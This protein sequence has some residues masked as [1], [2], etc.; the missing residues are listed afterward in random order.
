MID[1]SFCTQ[2]LC[3][4]SDENITSCDCILIHRCAEMSA[5]V[6]WLSALVAC[7][8]PYGGFSDPI[9]PPTTRG[10]SLDSSGVEYQGWPYEDVKFNHPIQSPIDIITSQAVTLP[11]PVLDIVEP[12]QP[13][14]K[15]LVYNNGHNVYVYIEEDPSVRPYLIGGPLKQKFIFQQMHFHWGA[16][17]IWG[18][19]HLVDGNSYSVEIHM[20]H[21]NA[22][23]ANFD[24]AAN[25]PDGLAVL[26]IFAESQDKDN[27]LLE[28]LYNLLPKLS[29]PNSS[30]ELSTPLVMQWPTSA[31]T[32]NDEY[33]TYP[34]SLTTEPYS[35][36]V[37][38]IVLPK[39]IKLSHK[40]LAAFREIHSEHH[41]KM[42]ANKRDVQP[43][44]QRPIVRSVSVREYL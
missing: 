1:L 23:Y 27:K 37:V 20:V 34:G 35:E 21:F 33:Y 38:F 10:I 36:N 6:F 16:Q 18:S 8:L 32:D 4:I 44:H 43:V 5:G 40:Q 11:L 9:K 25:K 30:Q 22:K 13:K 28:P 29:E 15:S 41:D 42:L 3:L 2:L 14:V 26:T 39:P 17:D 31:L 7:S 19:E 12:K 24:E